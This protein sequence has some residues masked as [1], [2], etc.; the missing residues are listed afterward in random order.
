MPRSMKSTEVARILLDAGAD[1]NCS[2]ASK[3]GIMHFNQLQGTE[4]LI[5]LRLC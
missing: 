5:W 3:L 2:P 4:I 1:V